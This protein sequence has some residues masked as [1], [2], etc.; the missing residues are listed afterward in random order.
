MQPGRD[1]WPRATSMLFAGGG[2]A[3]GQV[4]GA[5]D[6]RGEDV[7]ERPH[8][9]PRFPGHRLS[10]PGI[11]PSGIEFHDFAGRPIPILNEGTP[12]PEPRRS[13]VLAP[14]SA[15]GKRQRSQ[16]SF[17]TDTYSRTGTA[18]K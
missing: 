12:I 3:T 17:A 11:D 9:G 16:L 13:A 4:I 10:P 1:H 15:A 2:L 8:L 18:N 6:R 5:T 14:Q 7:V